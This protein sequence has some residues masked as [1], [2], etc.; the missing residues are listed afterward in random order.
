LVLHRTA[1]KSDYL[2]I[3]TPNVLR[4]NRIDFP[5][6]GAHAS[7]IHDDYFRLIDDWAEST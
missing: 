6:R 4:C 7:K 5:V 1:V 3:R 2:Q